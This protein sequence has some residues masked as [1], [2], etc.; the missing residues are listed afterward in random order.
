MPSPIIS[1]SAGLARPQHRYG[2]EI[3][4]DQGAGSGHRGGPD[5]QRR[6]RA[7]FVASVRL[8]GLA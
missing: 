6:L 7:R 3:D 2:G 4:F 1:T 5:A 8:I